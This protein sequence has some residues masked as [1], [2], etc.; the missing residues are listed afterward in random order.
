[1]AEDNRTKQICFRISATEYEIIDGFCFAEVDG[2]KIRVAD[3]SKYARE[4]MLR[5]LIAR[6]EEM[7]MVEEF[8]KIKASE[9]SIA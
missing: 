9:L 4:F 3:I 2:R 6:L 5:G 7:K 1:M 8:K